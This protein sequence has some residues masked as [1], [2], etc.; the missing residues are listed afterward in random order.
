[1][2]TADFK[3]VKEA[4]SVVKERMKFYN[5]M[6]DIKEVPVKP[7]DTSECDNLDRLRKEFGAPT[8]AP[9]LSLMRLAKRL[10]KERNAARAEIIRL[11]TR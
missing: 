8:S 2:K 1:M 10:E 3:C 4:R 9:Y 6:M 5:S 11:T 7:D